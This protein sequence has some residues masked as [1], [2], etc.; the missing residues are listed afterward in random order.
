[1]KH[2]KQQITAFL[3]RSMWRQL[4]S[5]SDFDTC[6]LNKSRVLLEGKIKAMAFI[7]TT[8]VSVSYQQRILMR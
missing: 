2:S 3:L 7:E 6:K 4:A 5:A 1:V 8:I